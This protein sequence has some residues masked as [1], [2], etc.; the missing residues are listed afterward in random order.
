MWHSER[1]SETAPRGARVLGV[2]RWLL[3]HCG[4]SIPGGGR[5]EPDRGRG[6]TVV[7]G[8]GRRAKAAQP[9]VRPVLVEVAGGGAAP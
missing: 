1:A 4:D 7:L 3:V 6:W 2:G 5:V 8:E 9:A